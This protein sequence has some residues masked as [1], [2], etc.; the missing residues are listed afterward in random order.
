MGHAYS[1]SVSSNQYR[2]TPL[3]PLRTAVVGLGY[4]GS[5]HAEKYATLPGSRLVGLVDHQ[6]ERAQKKAAELGTRV[7]GDHREL[8][9]QVDAV[10]VVTP[11]DQHFKVTRDLLEAGVHVLVEK[12][13]TQN[14]AEARELN[15]LAELHNAVLQVG[16]LERFNPAF[17]AL[18]AHLRAPTYMET[19]RL[20]RF[21]QRGDDVSVVLDLMIHD[22]DLV[23]ALIPGPITHIEARGLSVYSDSLDLVNAVLYFENGSVANLTASRASTSPQRTLHLF[24]EQS[25]TC[26]DMQ[27]KWLA[28]QELDTNGGL[29]NRR[30]QLAQQDIL[31]TE[32]ASFI[33]AVQQ[34]KNPVVTGADGL[35]A[36]STAVRITEAVALNRDTGPLPIHKIR[37]PGPSSNTHVT[38]DHHPDTQQPFF[39]RT[40]LVKSLARN[41]QLR[42]ETA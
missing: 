6:S 19:H 25:Y 31:R 15:R 34:G 12:P 8:I 10:S 28:I 2:P 14:P 26:L 27:N 3:K 40:S 9:G 39:A 29:A 18:P 21:Q 17:S 5:F 33:E 23:H 37:Y 38:H 41:A 11:A 32:L 22:I 20:T 13:I 16:H 36:L 7:F 4:Y 1:Q 30:T 42:G 24:Q 35:R